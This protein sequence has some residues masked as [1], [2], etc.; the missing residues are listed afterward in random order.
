M[1]TNTWPLAANEEDVTQIMPC[2]QS[3]FQSLRVVP[4]EGRQTLTSPDYFTY[5]PP[6]YTDAFSLYIKGAIL[7][8]RVKN[9]NARFHRHHDQNLG[10]TATYLDPRR[11]VEF[12]KMEASIVGL[13]GSIPKELADP[14][15]EKRDG[16]VDPV[17]YLAHLLPHTAMILL[18]DPH[19]QLENPQCTST[20]QIM[21]AV[22]AILALIYKICS[23]S[24]DLLHLDHASSLCWFIAGA[25]LV[26]MIK[27]QMSI[28]HMEEAAR[29]Q[30]E[31]QVI[32][33]MLGTLGKKV[34]IG[35]RQL[36]LLDDL[37]NSELG[38]GTELPNWIQVKADVVAD[39]ML[40]D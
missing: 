26:R 21:T 32:R 20:A 2:T 13:I 40:P 34:V 30:Q 16:K 25:A 1:A 33:F 24:F 18:H 14:T 12:Q 27:A 37:Y 10:Q 5:H 11:S 28:G 3:D 4:R 31:L 22:Q 39:I 38:G 7:L 17:L 23:T 9:F 19:A 29:M 8:G 36:N 35:L 15:N 6:Q